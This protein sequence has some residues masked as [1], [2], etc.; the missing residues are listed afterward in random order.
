MEE[1]PFL[2][3]S[4]EEVNRCQLYITKKRRYCKF[5]PTK[6]QNFCI[7]HLPRDEDGQVSGPA[8]DILV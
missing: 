5:P 2:S 3:P 1:K 8:L 7:Q 4:L 6:G